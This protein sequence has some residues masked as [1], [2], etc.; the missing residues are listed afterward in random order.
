[1]YQIQMTVERPIITFQPRNKK[2]PATI[3]DPSTFQIIDI[4]NGKKI[5]EF[6][7]MDN[8]LQYMI[9]KLNCHQADLSLLVA[10]HSKMKPISKVGFRVWMT[11]EAE[12][13]MTELHEEIL[14]LAH[15]EMTKIVLERYEAEAREAEESFGG[16]DNL[17]DE[18]YEAEIAFDQDPVE[19]T[20][21]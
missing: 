17:I 8:T 9:N 12:K 20:E 16:E 6:E 3:Y 18:V 11:V 15:E 7:G 21:Q 19:I 4:R 10:E 1:M 13:S 2:K 14:R 5:I